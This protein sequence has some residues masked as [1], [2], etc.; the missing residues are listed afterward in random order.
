M[1]VLTQALAWTTVI[2][3]IFLL[4]NFISY[5]FP[6]SDCEYNIGCYLVPH[7]LNL[8]LQIKGRI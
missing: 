1:S 4:Y 6:S 2:L 3:G 5:V 7:S 8:T